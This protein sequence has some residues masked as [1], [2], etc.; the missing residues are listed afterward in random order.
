M[1]GLCFVNINLT[2]NIIVFRPTG[3]EE[4]IIRREV[5]TGDVE[6]R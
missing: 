3:A 6:R 1:D 4:R 2:A 5:M